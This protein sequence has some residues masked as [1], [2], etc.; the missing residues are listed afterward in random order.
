MAKQSPA[1]PRNAY[2]Q[3]VLLLAKLKTDAP[4]VEKQL[5][6]LWRLF[7]L[8]IPDDAKPQKVE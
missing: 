2:E 4:A 8:C 7:E 5:D 1:Q 6:D 3:A